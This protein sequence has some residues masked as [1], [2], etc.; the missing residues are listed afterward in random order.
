MN[1]RAKSIIRTRFLHLIPVCIGITLNVI[2]GNVMYKLGQPFF[3]DTVGTVCVATLLGPFYGV[4]TAVISSVV[5]TIVFPY[6]FY[7]S[8]IYAFVAI[9]AAKI[10]RRHSKRILGASI[11]FILISALITGVLCPLVSLGLSVK[12]TASAVSDTIVALGIEEGTR[13]TVAYIILNVLINIVDKTVVCGIA[14]MIFRFIP[15]KTLDW[16]KGS[17]WLQNPLPKEERN[18]ARKNVSNVRY[19][20]RIRTTEMVVMT[21]LII[22]VSVCWV[23][24]NQYFSNEKEERIEQ[25]QGAVNLAAGMLDADSV[26]LFLSEGEDAPGM[27]KPW[28]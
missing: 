13:F 16:L 10:I 28:R 6:S 24:I 2:L 18:A 20:V 26:E 4:L 23:S 8:F 12:T 15:D 5:C 3:M 7:Y 22:V 27:R 17:R 25:A 19:S 21:A 14:I 9:F 1:S 11:R